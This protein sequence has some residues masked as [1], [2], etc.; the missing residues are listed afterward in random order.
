MDV[1]WVLAQRRREASVGNEGG[2]G[3]GP[4]GSALGGEGARQA[5][6]GRGCWERRRRE[7]DK[8]G[9][10]Q[11]WP[12]TQGPG[13]EVQAGP[14]LRAQS[15]PGNAW[16]PK[17]RPHELGPDAASG[18]VLDVE[19][20]GPVPGAGSRDHSSGR[21]LPWAHPAGSPGGSRP[22]L[23]PQGWDAPSLV[24]RALRVTPRQEAG[25]VGAEVR[26]PGREAGERW[27]PRRGS[28]PG[29]RSRAW[30]AALGLQGTGA[31]PPPPP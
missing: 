14:C 12:G 6:R 16:A 7:G 9:H 2:R 21:P 23:R 4:S 13:P 20:E 11:A 25:L 26:A 5:P 28:A 27:P 17:S 24:P 22:E 8:L 29:G 3:A 19:G 31:P 1:L 30:R 10:L 18:S 15:P